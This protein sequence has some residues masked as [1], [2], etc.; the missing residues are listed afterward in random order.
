MNDALRTNEDSRSGRFV[1]QWSSQDRSFGTVRILI[2]DKLSRKFVT[3][4][5]NSESH[6]L[7]CSGNVIQDFI[8]EY[9]FERLYQH[10]KTCF[11]VHYLFWMESNVFPLFLPHVPEN[12]NCGRSWAFSV[13]FFLPARK[14]YEKKRKTSNSV[15]NEYF[16]PNKFYDDG[17]VAFRKNSLR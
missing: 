14:K 10:R 3:T 11:G 8:A 13:F 15:Q 6:V 7:D 5:I 9:C 17:G 2:K 1:F 12:F 4:R 16:T